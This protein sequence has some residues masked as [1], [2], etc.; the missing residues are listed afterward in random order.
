[1]HPTLSC[2]PDKPSLSSRRRR[3]RPP[4]PLRQVFDD[5]SRRAEQ[6]DP[7]ATCRLAIARDRCDVIEQQ[8]ATYDELMW[9][10]QRARERKV[11]AT[12]EGPNLAGL[13]GRPCATPRYR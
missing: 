6:G 8:L 5:L 10:A 3:Y 7:A 12:K 13:G 9:R 1:M 11:V 2:L 4:T